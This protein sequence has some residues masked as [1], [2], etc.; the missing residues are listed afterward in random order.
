MKVVA[1]N[2]SVYETEYANPPFL[3]LEQNENYIIFGSILVDVAES[4]YGIL[5]NVTLNDIQLQSYNIFNFN[6]L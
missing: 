3:I 1:Q 2:I 6:Q 4:A 5:L